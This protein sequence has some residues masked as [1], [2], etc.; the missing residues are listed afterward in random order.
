MFFVNTDES[1]YA[2]FFSDPITTPHMLYSHI[3]YPRVYG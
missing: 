3:Q 1:E 2:P